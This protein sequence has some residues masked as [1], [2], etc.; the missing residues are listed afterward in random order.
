MKGKRYIADKRR[1]L[2][3]KKKIEKLAKL[4]ELESKISTIK[5]KIKI[6]RTNG[7]SN[8]KLLAC[9]IGIKDYLSFISLCEKNKKT[10]SFY[11]RELILKELEGGKQDENI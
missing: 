11:L 4:K 1:Y 7:I 8:S 2:K 6:N 3:F 5:N 9:K 10:V